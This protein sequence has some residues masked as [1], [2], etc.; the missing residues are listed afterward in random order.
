MYTYRSNKTTDHSTEIGKVLG[1]VHAK[2]AVCEQLAVIILDMQYCSL[3]CTNVFALK[4]PVHYLALTG[5]HAP[6][7]SCQHIM[8]TYTHQ[9]QH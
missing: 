3:N 7:L 6:I 4:L 8:L 9:L 1:S 2:T 5:I